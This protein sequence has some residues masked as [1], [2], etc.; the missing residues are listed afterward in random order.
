MEKKNQGKVENQNKISYPLHRLGVRCT[1]NIQEKSLRAER[2]LIE[3]VR[4][5]TD[6]TARS[7]GCL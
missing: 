5:E 3:G 2:C 7:V 6:F 1:F 4:A